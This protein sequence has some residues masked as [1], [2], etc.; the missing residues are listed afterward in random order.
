MIIGDNLSS[1]FSHLVVTEAANH[2]I[3][4]V[5]LPPNTTHLCQPLD[6]AI[7]RPVK[8]AWRNILDNW[9]RES[10]IKGSIPK[11]QFPALLKS[12][13]DRLSAD[14]LVAGFRA[15]GIFPLDRKEVLKRLPQ[16]NQ[17]PGGA[18]TSEILNDSVLELLQD[19]CGMGKK[20]QK[21]S[22]KRGYKIVLGKT[23]TLNC[24]PSAESSGS[25]QTPQASTSNIPSTSAVSPPSNSS[26]AN[27]EEWVCAVCKEPWEESGDDRWILCDLC[28]KQLHL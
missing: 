23:V 21:R 20:T 1:H 18:S 27:G 14:N 4:F 6:V 17:D 11:N 22:N 13:C 24:L 19:H 26:S 25:L 12:L 8:I 9:R 15:S 28:D 3:R 16:G 5:T 7:F 2:N 10:R